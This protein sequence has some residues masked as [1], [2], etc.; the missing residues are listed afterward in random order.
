MRDGLPHGRADLLKDAAFCVRLQHPEAARDRLR[1][2]VPALEQHQGPLTQ[3]FKKQL[4]ERLRWFKAPSR[5]ERE[6]Q[7]ADEH[8]VRRDYLRAAIFM[9]EACIT[10]ETMAAGR[11]V[12]HFKDR[13]DERRSVTTPGTYL[14][15]LANLR[16]GMAHGVLPTNIDTLNALRDEPSLRQRLEALRMQL[17]RPR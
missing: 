14:L 13:D 12:T 11:D 15:E 3:M 2:V 9:Q 7:L 17:Y 8:L 10:R 16:N 5:Q 4:L 6:L 1:S